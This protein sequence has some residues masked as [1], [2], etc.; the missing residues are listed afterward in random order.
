MVD[1]S[2]T[3]YAVVIVEWHDAHSASGW[4]GG[5]AATLANHDPSVCFSVGWLIKQDKVGISLVCS[6]ADD[7]DMGEHTFIDAGMV[8]KITVLRKARKGATRNST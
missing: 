2:D 3:D 8:R 4:L 7:D 1:R 5:R 6:V